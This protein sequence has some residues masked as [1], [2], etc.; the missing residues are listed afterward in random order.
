LPF[1]DDFCVKVGHFILKKFDLKIFALILYQ[2]V[3]NT[4]LCIKIKE[5]AGRP[6]IFNEQIALE[7][8]A[9]LFWKQGFEATSMDDLL[10]TMGLQKGSFYHSFGSKKELYVKA[11]DWYETS[12]SKDFDKLFVK[13]KNPIELIKAMFIELANC[14]PEE[15]QK[16][17]FMGNTIAELSNIDE[18]LVKKAAKNLQ[19]MENFFF[20]Q[21]K[22]AQETGELKTR[23]DAKILAMYLLNLWNGINI[24]RRIYP[25][26]TDLLALIEFQLAVLK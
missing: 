21:I 11:I 18:E 5:M 2:L 12:S 13:I 25:E 23:T 6:K 24:T 15:H 9:N 10:K 22:Q 20:E 1:F 26:K 16:G 8:A 7:N 4:H 14:S 17:C 3:Q 19:D